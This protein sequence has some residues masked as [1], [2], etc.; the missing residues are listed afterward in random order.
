[1]STT[2]QIGINVASQW[3]SF[4]LLGAI[5]VFLVPFLI[6]E[7]GRDLYGLTVLLGVI[8]T[9]AEIADLGL[10][11]ALGR[12]LAEAITLGDTDTF[13]RLASTAAG[14]W[15]SVGTIMAGVW[16][17][18][19]ADIVDF[20]DIPSQ[21]RADVLPLIVAFGAA[22]ILLAFVDPIFSAI[23]SS[24]NRFDVINS[25]QA[26]FGLL[27]GILLLSVLS[28]TSY[29]I[30]AWAVV[31]L[32][33]K[34]F[35]LGF[36]AFAAARLVP[37]FRLSPSL[38]DG[39]SFR[40]LFSLSGFLFFLNLTNILSVNADP[41][42]ISRF[43]GPGTLA[44]YNPGLGLSSRV[45]PMVLAL[46]NQLY[47]VTT[48]FHSTGEKAQMESA[49]F[50]G[51]RITFSMGVG[52]FAV[53]GLFSQDICRVWLKGT[54]G[55]DYRIAG[56]VLLAWALID[57]F[58]A[59]AG[60][61][62]AVMIGKN[63]VRFVTYTQ[64]PLSVVNILASIYLVG[65]TDLGVLGVLIPTVLI[66]AFRRLLTTVYVNRLLALRLRDYFR[67]AYLRPLIISSILIPAGVLLR[68][69]VRV[70]SV[71][72]LT[73]VVALTAMLWFALFFTLGVKGCER[74]T[75][76]ASLLKRSFVKPREQHV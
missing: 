16:V 21:I 35:F 38:I 63:K 18:F 13:N 60:T 20:L 23:L 12:H 46:A 6:R 74:S 52:I 17:A 37:T 11:A 31:T 76:F 56:Q 4:V 25:L 47:P 68:I 15:L 66:G 14:I 8:V 71:L 3:A 44:L 50:L 62:W 19:A 75:V 42:I 40:K 55:D 33:C 70:E 49:L 51:T 30:Y 65:Y 32:G 45:R 69:Y 53:L 28:V 57:L 58:Q 64:F 22:S 29:G 1:M 41:I 36:K 9:F 34:L 27:V 10:R 39:S 59:A 26:G 43:L 5:G 54:L 7:L 24:N 72:D 73:V 67:E 61:Q 2:R 48:R